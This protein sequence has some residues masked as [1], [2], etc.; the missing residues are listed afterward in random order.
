MALN[1]NILL[2]FF[3][4]GLRSFGDFLFFC[5]P[6]EDSLWPSSPISGGNPPVEDS[7]P[8]VVCLN[9]ANSH[10]LERSSLLKAF[11]YQQVGGYTWIL[12]HFSL[13][14]HC[15]ESICPP[16]LRLVSLALSNEYI[17]APLQDEK[18]P[19]C[20]S[21]WGPIYPLAVWQSHF[22]YVSSEYQ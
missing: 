11:C 9:S 12:W 16:L 15:L 22:T 18:P 13:F 2:K 14:Q 17:W 20:W 3:L 7:Q 19:P 6:P 4:V 1:N 10:N 21:P 8:L 5:R